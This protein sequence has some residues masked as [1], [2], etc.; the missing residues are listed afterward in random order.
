MPFYWGSMPRTIFAQNAIC[1]LQTGYIFCFIDFLH[2]IFFFNYLIQRDDHDEPAI[3][4]YAHSPSKKRCPSH[5]IVLEPETAPFVMDIIYL[6]LL[7]VFAVHQ[8]LRHG[9]FAVASEARH[10][11]SVFCH[12]H[13][14]RIPAIFSR[15]TCISFTP[16]SV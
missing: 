7:L 4:C 3:L 13:V 2:P 5:G 14:R 15:I 1:G 11:G 9:D 8:F 16:P 12:T 6:H 10:S